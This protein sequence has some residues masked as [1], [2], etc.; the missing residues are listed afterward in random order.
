MSSFPECVSVLCQ[1]FTSKLDLKLIY[2]LSD[3][4]NH[5]ELYVVSVD[6]MCR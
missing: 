3:L 6:M 2:C 5:F 4:V 1:Y